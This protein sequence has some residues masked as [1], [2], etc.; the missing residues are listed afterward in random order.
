MPPISY[1]PCKVA[2][3]QR[4]MTIIEVLAALAIGMA[5]L[6]GLSRLVDT[7]LEETRG[8][9]SAAY[10][11]QVVNAA[12]SFINKNYA[13]L[14]QL[15][16]D[17]TRAYTLAQLG[18]LAPT[19]IQ[20]ANPYGQT[21]CV[22][23]RPR[24]RT[25]NG[26]DATVLDVLVVTEG[27]A[28]RAI[29]DRN[30]AYTAAMAGPGAGYI[31][32]STPTVAQ[33]ASGAWRL[34]GATAPT[35]SAF[36]TA[37]CS[38][39]SFGAGSLVTALFFD[40]PGQQ[41]SDFLYRNRIAGM[42]HLNQMNTPIRF[43][44]VVYEKDG[45]DDT[46]ELAVDQHR[47]LMQCN[48]DGKWHRASSWKESVPTFTALASLPPNEVENG[49]VRLVADVSRAFAYS[50]AQNKWVALS[51]DE[52]GDLNVPRNVNALNG[53]LHT[54][55]AVTT[56]F[57]VTP[58]L[59][60]LWHIDPGT[61]CHLPFYDDQGM[62]QYYTPIGSMVLGGPNNSLPVVCRGTSTADARFVYFDG[63]AQWK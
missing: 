49:D 40:S 54:M 13:S 58:S 32:A 41:S 53:G 36:Q 50:S 1:F 39:L 47:N 48:Q 57:M 42:E 46:A 28:A 6:V 63:S 19:G 14:T 15:P 61:P 45:C 10:Q 37:R 7:S 38:A 56:Q 24:V 11:T 9:Q 27:T 23:V 51:F 43:G 20:G 4:G 55:Y 2:A 52:K 3:R 8:V 35:L 29:P 62:L 60:L 30:L 44:M 33:S 22:L 17:Q 59:E 25:V 26:A 34:D 31:L 12:S 21:P 16:V 18:T 5:L